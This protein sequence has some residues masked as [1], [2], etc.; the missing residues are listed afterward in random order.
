MVRALHEC[1]SS[2]YTIENILKQIFLQLKSDPAE[3]T[4]KS[5][6]IKHGK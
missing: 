3:L 6:M 4:S 1:F 2:E 5:N